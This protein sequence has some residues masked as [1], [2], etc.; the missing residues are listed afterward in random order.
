MAQTEQFE[1]LPIGSMPS[2]A[3]KLLAYRLNSLCS[4][5]YFIK[6]VLRRHRLSDNLHKP[7]C[8]KL[9]REHLKYLL[10]MPRDHFKSTIGSEG[11]PMWRSMP[12]TALEEDSLAKL[13]YSND[14]ISSISRLHNRDLRTLIVTE[15]ITNAKKLGK[16]IHF[17][18][19]FN[20]LF[21]EVFKSVLPNSACK[22][23]EESMTHLRSNASP[24]GEGTYDFIGVGGALQSRHYD[25][26]VE[27]DLQGKKAAD[28]QIV[29]DY[30]INYHQLLAGAWDSVP[31][32]PDQ[33]GDE[34]V[35]GNRWAVNDL[36]S[37]I[38]DN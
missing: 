22:W 10:E 1:I 24:H 21:R 14:F 23:T 33:L 38:K 11:L 9:Q 3:T 7:I 26:M 17:H 36:N 34:L 35:I 28:S 5:Y 18:Y 4:L 19:Y 15:V 25:L 6:V 20:D 13:G 8:E 16:R 37:W 31:G 2:E 32:Q 29:M 12:V 27:D 30:T